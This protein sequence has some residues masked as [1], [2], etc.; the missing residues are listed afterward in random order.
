MIEVK[1][2]HSRVLVKLAR[3]SETG[4]L[5]RHD[6]SA[7]QKEKLMSLVATQNQELQKIEGAS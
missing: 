5:G 4:L 2:S 6:E 1:A 7:R 3:T